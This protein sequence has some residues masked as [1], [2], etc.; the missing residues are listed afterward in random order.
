MPKILLVDDNETLREMY[1]VALKKSNF[2][3]ET[4]A[5]AD[6]DFADKVAAINPD[7]VS[8][9]ILMPGGVNGY[10][11]LKILKID[12]RTKNIPVFLLSNKGEREDI[13]KGISLGAV[14]YLIAAKHLP[15][16]VVRFFSAYLSMPGTY[17]PQY[18]HESY[19]R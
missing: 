3:V 8:L 11:A 12:S 7:L 19:Y 4:L 9:D 18:V 2:I 6:T 14:D 15:D 1:C 5:G 16:E 13:T 10:Q 17:E